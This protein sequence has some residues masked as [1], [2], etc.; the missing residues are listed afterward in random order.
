MKILAI[1]LARKGSKRIKNKNLIKIG[2]IKLV[3]KTI[4][5]SKKISLFENILLSTDDKKILKIG[6]KNN[7]LAPW[8]RPKKLSKDKSTSYDALIHAYKWYIKKYGFMDGIF[9][10]Q[11]TSPFRKIK[12][13]TGMINLFKKNYFR[14]VVSVTKA[15]KP[16]GWFLKIRKNKNIVPFI[17]KKYFNTRSQD[18][19]DVYFLNGVGYLLN[20][21]DI[22][23]EK[24]IIPS[25]SIAYICNSK[26]E[27]LDID[28]KEDLY[29]ARAISYYSNKFF[30]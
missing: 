8:L 19:D 20:P 13:I 12:T 5:L 30:I 24:T 23:L 27:S 14:S 11:P 16:P 6:K 3:E 4:L 22:Q 7:I 28:V 2:R 15:Y 10:L 21:R 25:N 17:D 29:I 18:F 1:I 9:L 26:I